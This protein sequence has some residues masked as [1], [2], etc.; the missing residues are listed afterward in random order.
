MTVFLM[1]FGPKIYPAGFRLV[2]Y[3]RYMK[4]LPIDDP[5]GG[6]WR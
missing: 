3:T 2:E 4:S 5:N 6:V 1:M